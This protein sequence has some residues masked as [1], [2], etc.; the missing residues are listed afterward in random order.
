M[1]IATFFM[2]TQCKQC[3]HTKA[4]LQY[5]RKRSSCKE[6][7]IKNEVFKPKK[8]RYCER[9]NNMKQLREGL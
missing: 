3:N 8:E 4:R 5:R 1:E 7:S 9:K 2:Y 6:N